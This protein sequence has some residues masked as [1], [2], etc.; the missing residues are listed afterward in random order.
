MSVI[1]EVVLSS[2]VL[3]RLLHATL[4]RVSVR[5]LRLHAYPKRHGEV[6]LYHVAEEHQ[7]VASPVK[8]HRIV[9]VVDMVPAGH[10]LSLVPSAHNP[11]T[12]SN[13]EVPRDFSGAATQLFDSGVPDHGPGKGQQLEWEYDI[14]LRE[15]ATGRVVD[16]IDPPVIIKED[17]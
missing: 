11:V 12:L 8:P 10:T 4:V 9:F 5:D 1:D 2:P 13:L 7:A 14:V 15:D 17:P 16:R 6:V 3:N